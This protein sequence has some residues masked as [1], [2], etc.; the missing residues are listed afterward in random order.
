LDHSDSLHELHRRYLLQAK[1]TAENRH[2]L[3][4]LAKLETASRVLEVGS[5][6]GAILHEISD[7]SS[8][9]AFG[10][11]SDAQ[12]VSFAKAF[13]AD[14]NYAIGDGINLPFPNACFDICLCHFL[15]L[16][17]QDPQA[18]L[19]EMKRITKSEGMILALAEPDYGGRIDYPEELEPMGREQAEALR[20]QGA[21]PCMG[22]KLRRLFS[23]ADLVNV[24]VGVLGGQWYGLPDQMTINS[25]NANLS[26]DLGGQITAKEL[27]A[28]ITA[29]QEAWSKGHRLLYVPTFYASGMIPGSL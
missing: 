6:T 1:W 5:G 8:A 13:D 21:D 29:N 25:E 15:L 23:D 14:T 11:D 18:L 28:Y 24:H 10:I 16:W 19:E 17:V 26:R 22:R 3:Y 4:S 7:M 20:R 9:H 2:T 12:V 27:D